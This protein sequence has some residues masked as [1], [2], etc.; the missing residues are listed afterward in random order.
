MNE[1]PIPEAYS[2]RENTVAVAL[3]ST[4]PDDFISQLRAEKRRSFQRAPAF[5]AL[6]PGADNRD[7]GFAGP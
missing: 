5:R 1:V 3:P 4:R 7:Q 2:G 6:E